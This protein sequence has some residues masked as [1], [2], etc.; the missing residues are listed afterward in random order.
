MADGGNS[1]LTQPWVEFVTYEPRLRRGKWSN[2][3]NTG[4]HILVPYGRC[5]VYI[6]GVV[7]DPAIF[8]AHHGTSIVKAAL[9]LRYTVIHIQLQSVHEA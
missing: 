1:T 4:F 5:I 8:Q 3:R 6:P 7:T 9:V 2:V